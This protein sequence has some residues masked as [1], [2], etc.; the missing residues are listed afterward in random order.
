M[1]GVK[2]LEVEDFKDPVLLISFCSPTSK[3]SF[4]KLN[5][6]KIKF[7]YFLNKII[8]NFIIKINNYIKND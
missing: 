7:N 4:I 8:N 3:S 6:D 1:G 5:L 2:V